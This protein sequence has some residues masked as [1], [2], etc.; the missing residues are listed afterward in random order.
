[1][2]L[3]FWDWLIFL[4]LGCLSFFHLRGLEAV[5]KSKADASNENR[6]LLLFILDFDDFS[7]MTCLDSFL[8]LYRILP[9]RFKTSHSW[10]VLIVDKPEDNRLIRIAGKKLRGFLKANHITF[11]ILMD[12]SGIF[13]HREETG[14]CVLLFDEAKNML[15]RYEFPLTGGQLEE[16]FLYLTE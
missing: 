1:M 9:F 13:G 2:N 3:K 8:A 11:P 6:K 16:I 5:S 14:S 12:R 10:G 15:T 4:V 7:C